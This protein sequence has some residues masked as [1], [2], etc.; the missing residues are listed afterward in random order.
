MAETLRIALVRPRCGYDEAELQEPLGAEAI[1]GYL[2]KRG[3][4]CRVFDRR[5]G[6][7]AA[8]LAAY[9]PDWVGFSLM[10]EDDVPDA[11]RLLQMLK[12]EGRRFFAGGLFVTVCPER[13]QALFPRDTVLI[14][15]EG[16]A[17]VFALV[18]GGN[19]ETAG[20]LHPDDWAFAG[21]DD[22]ETYLRRGGVINLRTAR[23]CRGCCAFCTTPGFGLRYEARSVAL[24]AEEMALLAGRGFEPVFNFTDDEFGDWER[25]RS[26]E[27]ELELRGVR[28]AFSME[29]RA[30]ALIRT[31][32]S[33]WPDLHA[34]GLCRVFTGLESFDP[35]T[36][37]RWGKAVDVPALLAT[38]AAMNQ[39]GIVTETGY[40]LWHGQTTPDS[41]L[42]ELGQLYEHGLL[43]PKAAL[44]RM[45]L[46]P[47]SRLY[48]EAGLRSEA[49]A[50]LRPAA[51]ALYDRWVWLL[52]P[53]FPLWK[54][55]AL[56]M[57]GVACRA[58]LSGDRGRLDALQGV[59][60][61]IAELTWLSLTGGE[62][63]DPALC[64]ET[65]GDL[66]AICSPD[67]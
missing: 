40:I 10:T 45:I 26:L 52:E 25:I 32:A 61:R 2:R 67:S 41:V 30:Q 66:D 65:G 56:A 13:S 62:R 14:P 38:L 18:T 55:A 63:T 34:G 39:A 12:T 29:L 37:R 57:P 54:R 28:A 43:S 22:L 16:E 4:E 50:P 31:P 35:E 33:C 42:R 3:L 23:G 51:A 53:L 15:G 19:P 20:K 48:R 1:C 9:G 11:L 58:Q 8:D 46:Y 47:G 36:R 6:A 60:S 27:E 17:P 7:S 5:L 49:P 21:R 59:L 64:R 24:V 44:S